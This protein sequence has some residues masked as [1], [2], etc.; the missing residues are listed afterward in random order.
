MTAAHKALAIV[1][2]NLATSSKA[3]EAELCGERPASVT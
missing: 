1:Y 2:R 3:M